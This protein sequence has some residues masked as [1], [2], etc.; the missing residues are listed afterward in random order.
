MQQGRA[1][2][3]VLSRG[4]RA[5]A[6]LA[7]CTAP[8]AA[9]PGSGSQLWASSSRSG[10]CRLPQLP[11]PRGSAG[12]AACGA[13]RGGAGAGPGLRRPRQSCTPA[14]R[15]RF[16]PGP[17]T[18]EDADG[19]PHPHGRCAG[20]SPRGPGVSDHGRQGG[21]R[22]RHRVPRWVPRAGPAAAAVRAGDGEALGPAPRAPQPLA[23]DGKVGA[24]PHPA[25]A[26]GARVSASG[27]PGPGGRG[28]SVGHVHAAGQGADTA[29]RTSAPGGAPC[30]S[31]PRG[32]ASRG[33]G[34]SPGENR[35]PCGSLAL[36]WGCLRRPGEWL[37][38]GPFSQ[39][40]IS[41]TQRGGGGSLGG[42]ELWTCLLTPSRPG[43]T[44]AVGVGA[45]ALG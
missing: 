9:T 27:D 8:A 30:F 20:G 36:S 16:R 11:R 12:R 31:P 6:R 28:R 15:R 45:A 21:R 39:Q 37:A 44:R 29:T 26:G 41:V 34:T 14:A 40:F 19:D 5:R 32:G 7:P 42:V 18:A 25:L 23:G 4:G 2:Q 22:Q 1:L 24:P 17:S 13:G 43:R 3:R 33:P 38:P 35:F 10:W